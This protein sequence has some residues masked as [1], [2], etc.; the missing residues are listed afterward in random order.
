MKNWLLLEFGPSF[1]IATSPLLVK[2][3]LEWTSSIAKI[4]F[5]FNDEQYENMSL[6]L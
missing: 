6:Y 2:R 4:I 3:S 1:A 5:H